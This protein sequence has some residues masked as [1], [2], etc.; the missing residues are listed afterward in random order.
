M[1]RPT[2]PNGQKVPRAKLVMLS[3]P[4]TDQQQGRLFYRSL[5]GHAMVHSHYLKEHRHHAPTSLGVNIDVGPPLNP[6]QPMMAMFEVRSLKN[7]VKRLTKLGGTVMADNVPIPVEP[8]HKKALGPDWK[9]IYKADVGDSMGNTTIM[10]DPFGNGII[11]IEMEKWA[12]KAYEA[13]N[14]S[15]K[16]LGIHAVALK[17][18]EKTFGLD[19]Y[20]NDPVDPDD[21]INSDED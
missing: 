20:K 7:T 12:E 19:E 9:K 13:G 15:E 17:V 16:E 14:L 5:L 11:L 8:G 6:G 21:D 10:K 18:A 2:F 3:I 1:P 4:V